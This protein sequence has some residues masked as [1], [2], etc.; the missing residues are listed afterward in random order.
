[1]LKQLIC[2]S[3]AGIRPGASEEYKIDVTIFMIICV[4]L[5]IMGVIYMNKSF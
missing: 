1:M 3:N 4:K 5:M 2:A